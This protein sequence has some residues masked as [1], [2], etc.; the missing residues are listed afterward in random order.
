[1]FFCG[2]FSKSDFWMRHV[3]NKILWW[4]V[5][6]NKMEKCVILVTLQVVKRKR[7]KDIGA[8]K[9]MF[10]ERSISGFQ[11]L[12]VLWEERIGI[13]AE[14]KGSCHYML[15]SPAGDQQLHMCSYH[16]LH[17]WSQNSQIAHSMCQ[18]FL[19]IIKMLQKWEMMNLKAIWFFFIPQTLMFM[20]SR[21]PIR[22]F[23]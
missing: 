7:R 6:C 18:V 1:M 17:M 4:G 22:S 10:W 11:E 3:I 13:K 20:K 5:S 12:T 21:R 2:T 14:N 19:R 8:W 23:I 16:Y 9:Q 15:G